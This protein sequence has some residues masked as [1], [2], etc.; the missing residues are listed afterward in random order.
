MLNKFILFGLIIT[1]FTFAFYAITGETTATRF[2]CFLATLFSI[3]TFAVMR[4]EFRK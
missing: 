1:A 3:F 2:P 4:E